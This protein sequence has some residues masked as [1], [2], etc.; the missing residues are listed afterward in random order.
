MSLW[1]NDPGSLFRKRSS[2]TA[3]L[4]FTE[5][6]VVGGGM[7]TRRALLILAVQAGVMGTLAHHLYKLQVVEGET[8]KEQARRNRTSRRQISPARGE[9]YDRCG[10]LVAGN[11]PNWRALVMVEE[12]TDLQAVVDRFATIVPLDERDRARIER[13]RKHIRRYVP[14]TL[15]EFLTWDDVARLGLNAPSLPGVLID[16]GTTREY[17]FKELM[18]HIIGYVAPP[19]ET[20]VQHNAAL[21]LPGMKIGRGG[22]EQTQ[23]A[24]LR[25]QPGTVEMEVNAYGRVMGELERVEGQPGARL[26]LTLDTVLQ[27]R[28]RERI[29]ERVASAVVMDCRNGEVMGLVS[30]PSFDPTLFDGGISRTQWNSLITDPATPLVDKAVSG[31]YPPGSTFKPAVA[32]AALKAHAITPSERFTCP[33]YYDMGG[34]RF[35]CWSRYGHGSINLHQALK[36]S[37]DVY[38]Y[39]VARRC[40]MDAIHEAA[41]SLGLSGHLPIELPHMRAGSVPTPEMRRQHGHHW[42]GGDTVNAGIGQ[43]LVQTTPLALAT[44]TSRLATGRM[45]QPHLVRTVSEKLVPE[46]IPPLPFAKDSLIA[47]RSGMFAV[48]NEPQGTAPQ[49]RLNLPGVQ[50][51]GKTGSAQVRNV[52]RALRESGHFNSMNL[53]WQYRPHALFI[54]FAPYDNPRYAVSVVVEHGNAGATEAAPLAAQI[55]TDTLVRDPANR[56]SLS[57]GVVARADDVSE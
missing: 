24:T 13:D 43:G 3:D 10:V 40:G 4:S 11:K 21:A 2:P 19:N 37:C 23:E 32:L 9:I 53:P 35:H 22:L 15:K 50:M 28:I 36:Y 5:E 57:R 44:Y 42:N 38:F 52:P 39:Q 33:G 55:M 46:D 6:Q 56:T 48:V 20:D 41:V 1:R 30:T 49:A 31:L 34:V 29:G 25:G 47:A 8:L 7:F 54:C 26:G 45:V 12:T 18:S 51:A 17:P 27:T 14:L 16:V